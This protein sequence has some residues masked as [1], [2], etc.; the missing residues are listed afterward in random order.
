MSPSGLFPALPPRRESDPRSP[1]NQSPVVGASFSSAFATHGAV[2]QGVPLELAL[3]PVEFR[4]L[5]TLAAN[6][7]RV[8]S[9]DRLLDNLYLD[10][11][12]VTDRTTDSHIKNLRRKLEQ[13]APGQDPIR[14]I[15]G[16]G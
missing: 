5:K 16:V 9:R 3:T 2:F 12:V 13:A 15:Y 14:S 8:F 7:G 4:L 6:P 11:R 1:G 10:H